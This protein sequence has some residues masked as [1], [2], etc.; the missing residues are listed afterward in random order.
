[1]NWKTFKTEK[2]PGFRFNLIDIIFILTITAITVLL[3]HITDKTEISFIP[4]YIGFTFFLFCNVFRIGNKLEA[5]WYI[6]FTLF[7][8]Y[9]INEMNIRLFWL[10]T[11]F[12]FEPFKILIFLHCIKSDSYIGAF[13]ERLKK[14]HVK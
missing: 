14:Q 5:L 3:F 1:M 11:L 10:G 13:Y 2:K 8:V 6:P 12:I 7:S 9:S 4:M